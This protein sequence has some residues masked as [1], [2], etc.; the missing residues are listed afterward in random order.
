MLSCDHEDEF[1]ARGKTYFRTSKGPDRLCGARSLRFNEHR[2]SFPGVKTQGREVDHSS[3]SSAEVKNECSYTSNTS[4][5]YS[6]FYVSSF[7]AVYFDN[8]SG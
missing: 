4:C 7:G 2:V 8:R 3:P 5:V 6:R 1:P